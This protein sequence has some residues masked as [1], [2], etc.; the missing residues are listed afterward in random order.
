MP[1]SENFLAQLSDANFLRGKLWD[2]DNKL[3]PLF[4]ATELAGEV[5]EACNVV[6]KIARENHGLPG[7][8]A[9][10][11]DLREE[12]SDVI[13]CV[14]LLANSLGIG[15]DLHLD[16]VKKFNKTSDKLGFAVRLPV[17]L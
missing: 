14:S 15:T 5:G 17:T 1:K 10:L 9:T 12:L 8:R 4:F 13:I 6:K 7:S 2:P 16:V 11:E 3:T